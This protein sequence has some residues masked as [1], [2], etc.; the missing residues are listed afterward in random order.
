MAQ[1]RRIVAQLRSLV[2]NERVEDDLS[3]EVA[4]HLAMLADDFERRGMSTE[5]ARTAA[6]RALGGAEQAKQAHR[7]ER[8]LLWIEQTIQDLRFGA[9]TLTR[10]PGFTI[11]AALTLAL[12]I[13]ASTAIFSA[14]NPILFQ[15]LPYPHADRIMM[16]QEMRRDGLPRRPT[17]GTFLGMKQGNQ[18]FEA[19]AVMKPWQPTMIGNLHPERLDG[20][21][22]SSDYFRALGILPAIGRDFNLQDDRFRGPNVVVL[23]DRLWLRLFSR[24]RAVLGKQIKLDDTLFTVIGV[25]PAAFENVLAPSAELWAPL[26]YDPSLPT[27]GKEWGH[28]LRMIGRLRGDVSANQA[29]D[30][31][32]SVLRPY[33][34]MYTKGYDCCGGVPNGIVVTRL[35]D[36]ITRGVKP[37]LLA[38]LG[39]VVLVLLIACVNVAN[40]LLA[41]SARRS[42]EFAMRIAL[43][44]GR[45]RLVRQLL[46]ESMLI[47]S[48]GGLLGIVI[49]EI[50]VRALVA[51]SPAGLPRVGAISVN[52]GA[53]AFC[54]GITTLVGLLVGF[55]PAVQTC[56]DDPQGAL[57]RGS[58]RTTAGGLQRTRQVLVISEVALS[59][60]LLVGAGLLL[61]SLTHLFAVDP[62]FDSEHLLTMQVQESGRRF[63]DDRV[64]AQFFNE[65]LE[66]VRQVPGVTAAAFTTQL[67]LS[68][69]LTVYG[70]Q[71]ESDPNG[72]S[73]GVLQYA[74]SPGYFDA[75]RI[76]LKAGRLL[77]EGDRAGTPGVVLI[78][79]S[80]AKRKFPNQNPV[81]QRVRIGLD[82]GH[83]E[84]PWAT[85]VGVVGDAK[86]AS[87]EVS[88]PDAFYTSM[89]QWFWVDTA[90]SLVVRTNDNPA[91]L[92][93]A[94][95]N[96]IW[97]IDKDQPIVRVATMDSLVAESQVER[98]FAL[99]LFEMFGMVALVL[100][101]VG[102]YG[103]LSSYVAERIREIGVRSALGAS[104]QDILFWIFR[105]GMSLTGLGIL[106]GLAGAVAT[107]QAITSM[108]Y[109]VSRFDWITYVGVSVLLA[110]VSGIACVLPAWSAA[111][112]DP[113]ITLR[114]S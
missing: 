30:Q 110:G 75:M 42:S 32:N 27:D 74:T 73:E 101:A 35:Q 92:A 69:D 14:V 13:G 76:P 63:G 33:A 58:V 89:T 108:L 96:A 3:R 2:G 40:L 11:T 85:I 68:G 53:F 106:I 78:S 24:D 20:Q 19:M 43:G 94:I 16:V 90:Q 67:P 88:A 21:R 9:R 37:A 44:A 77:D 105:R 81:G 113:S 59:V 55:A 91:N 61:R 103:V 1:W 23:S 82:A 39:A 62:G 26:Q 12:G 34:Q 95:K 66:A 84:R 93:Q 111:K 64:R 86:Q 48:I 97:S 107:S 100:A 28:H 4:S 22:V 49:A 29:I 71:F 46:T 38:I 56:R 72:S 98:H 36:E 6:L 79:E 17:Y 41:R 114:A 112:I 65:V 54:L 83:S 102:I 104:R 7:D 70:V 47:A 51:L 50:G 18:S 52:G 60:M 25:M 109:G 99:M 15:P 5:E 80:L 8:T 57:Q 10:N 87:L 31:L 45:L